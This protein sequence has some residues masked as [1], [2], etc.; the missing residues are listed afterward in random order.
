LCSLFIRKSGC[1]V[2]FGLLTMLCSD[3]LQM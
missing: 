3:T 2:W 1:I